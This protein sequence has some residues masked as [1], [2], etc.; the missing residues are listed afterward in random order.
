MDIN[1][2]RTFKAI[3]TVHGIEPG[4]LIYLDYN[5]NII[6]YQTK[7]ETQQWAKEGDVLGSFTLSDFSKCECLDDGG[8]CYLDHSSHYED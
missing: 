2:Y 4:L 8:Y 1:N 5:D 7:N 3:K 6:G